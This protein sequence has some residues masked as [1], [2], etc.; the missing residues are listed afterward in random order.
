MRYLVLLGAVAGAGVL[1][2]LW[3]LASSLS[4]GLALLI[5]VCL[6]WN[7]M[8]GWEYDGR[9]NLY[10]PPKAQGLINELRVKARNWDEYVRAERD[11]ERTSQQKAEIVRRYR[12]GW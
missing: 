11:Y 10:L 4:F 1:I 5:V 9:L 8:T 3:P 6:A 12:R 2:W 7:R